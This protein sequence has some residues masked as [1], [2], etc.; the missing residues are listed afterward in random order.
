MMLADL[1]V[2][3]GKVA[4]DAAP[5]AYS[6]A[7]IDDNLLGKP[8][9]TTRE[10]TFERLAS[11][12][13][14]DRSVE[15]YR[16]LRSIWDVDSRSQPM[17][18]LLLA[19]W[20]DPLLRQ[21]TPFVLALP[22]GSGLPRPQLGDQ[23]RHEYPQRFGD[24]TLRSIAQNLASSWT[25]A[26]YLRGKVAK[27][28]SRPHVTPVVAAFAMLLAYLR[29]GRGELLLTSSWSRLLDR[30]TNE[31]KGL[32]EEASKQGWLKFKSAGSVTEITFPN[33]LADTK[34]TVG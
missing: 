13:L 19:C 22:E 3:L 23:L 26:G 2:V 1:R 7:V 20:R 24:T 16:V 27:S 14:L 15:P 17:L 18:A 21:L 32:I 25:Q 29:G 12:Y 5:T 6:A 31:V 10:R 30:T 28:R 8:T 33:W 11:L 34:E 9:R 4:A